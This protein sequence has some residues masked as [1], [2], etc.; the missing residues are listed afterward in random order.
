MSLSGFIRRL[1]SPGSGHRPQETE[2]R[3][4]KVKIT[5]VADG[6]TLEGHDA[7]KAYFDREKELHDAYGSSIIF[8]VY[9]IN[10]QADSLQELQGKQLA[11]IKVDGAF[12]SGGDTVAAVKSKVRPL[13]EERARSACEE[14]APTNFSIDPG[15]RITLIFNGHP[16]ADDKLFYADH[17][18]L[19]PAWVQVF[20][21]GCEFAKVAER[22]TV[23]SNGN[24]RS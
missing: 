18:M 14:G 13:V 19:L 4:D 11:E 23:L 17:F 20:L 3:Y 1:F 24:R 15:D 10:L 16:M 5:N 8:Q 2:P 22:A 6:T 21:H 7:V 12:V 9:R